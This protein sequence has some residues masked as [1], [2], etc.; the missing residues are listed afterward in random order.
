M[1]ILLSATTHRSVISH[2]HGRETLW[3]NHGS[4]LGCPCSQSAALL[5]V[6]TGYFLQKLA[7]L[8]EVVGCCS[9]L[10]CQ[11]HNPCSRSLRKVFCS[12]IMVLFVTQV[13]GC[14]GSWQLQTWGSGHQHCNTVLGTLQECHSSN[15]MLLAVLLP[16]WLEILALRSAYTAV[17]FFLSHMQ[18]WVSLL[19]SHFLD[20]ITLLQSYI[21]VSSWVAPVSGW[22]NLPFIA[23]VVPCA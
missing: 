15:V 17:V 12:A 8:C 5:V 18:H 10:Q 14:W 16:H 11:L 4:W 2:C 19:G 1:W 6:L 3:W 7:S 13:L 20:A 9:L 22:W 21:R 23:L